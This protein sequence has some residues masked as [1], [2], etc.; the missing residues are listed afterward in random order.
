MSAQRFLRERTQAG[1][2]LE[3][4]PSAVTHPHWKKFSEGVWR[5][6]AAG[7]CPLQHPME[8]VAGGA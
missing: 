8:Q 5:S 3:C 7:P 2:I 1:F 6:G 4:S